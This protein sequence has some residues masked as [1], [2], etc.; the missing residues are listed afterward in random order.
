[1]LVY[2]IIVLPSE[3]EEQVELEKPR[4]SLVTPVPTAA[5]AARRAGLRLRDLDF[6]FA[7]ALDL[8]FVAGVVLEE[9]LDLAL[10]LALGTGALPSPRLLTTNAPASAI[11]GEIPNRR[12]ACPL[13]GG[14]KGASGCPFPA[15]L[16]GS[17]T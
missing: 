12:D 14:I 4:D 1:M 13:R 10:A 17:G 2:Y 5:A 8:A 15:A 16:L 3:W 9:A 6:A 7:F 11:S